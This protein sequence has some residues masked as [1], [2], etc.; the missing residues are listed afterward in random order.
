M[1]GIT[2]C[3]SAKVHVVMTRRE[4]QAEHYQTFTQPSKTYSLQVVIAPELKRINDRF[5]ITTTTPP[6]DTFQ[7]RQER[8]GYL[9]ESASINHD[10]RSTKRTRG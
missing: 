6:S 5:K 2:Q 8:Q 9:E 1:H 7:Q 3:E 10:G 4:I